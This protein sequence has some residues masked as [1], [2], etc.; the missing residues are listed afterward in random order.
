M[1][2]LANLRPHGKYSYT[3]EF[4]EVGGV[5]VLLNVLLKAGLIHG[6]TITCT[7]QTLAQSLAAFPADFPPDQDVVFPLERPFAPALA[8]IVVVRG[9]LCPEGAVIKLGGKELPRWRGPARVYDEEQLAFEAIMGA[10]PCLG[11]L[12]RFE[13]VGS[14]GGKRRGAMGR[15]PSQAADA[16]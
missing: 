1:P 3:Q 10:C 7:G 11:P 15:P 14:G 12:S 13:W 9:S 5:P 2:L 16:R 4:D 6:D 8:H